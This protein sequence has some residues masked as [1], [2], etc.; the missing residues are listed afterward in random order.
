MLLKNTKTGETFP[1]TFEGVGAC[2]PETLAF[3]ISEIQKHN[4]PVSRIVTIV[5]LDE[6]MAKGWI[7]P[8]LEMARD[9]GIRLIVPPIS[10]LQL[11][12]KQ[13][14]RWNACTPEGAWLGTFYDDETLERCGEVLNEFLDEFEDEFS[15]DD[16]FGVLVPDTG[17]LDVLFQKMLFTKVS[18]LCGTSNSCKAQCLSEKGAS[19]INLVPMHPSQ[20]K[21]IFECLSD[22]VL[23]DVYMDPPRSICP[24]WYELD[25][26]IAL[27]P[28]YIE[29][30]ARVIKA[31]GTEVVAQLLDHDYLMK[32]A[33]SRQILVFLEVF[34]ACNVTPYE[35]IKE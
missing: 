2:D 34:E 1:F 19:S 25:T 8:M 30:G 14:Q 33:I 31:E 16:C 22:D 13:E 10:P 20:V 24:P 5:G 28:E 3:A 17:L 15:I 4:L 26:V 6:L 18:V 11:G 27:A 12:E 21:E 23:L 29:A 35:V 9:A 32:I 7:R